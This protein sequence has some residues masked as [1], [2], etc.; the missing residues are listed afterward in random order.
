[1][2]MLVR[3]GVK[4]ILLAEIFYAYNSIAF[5]ILI[6]DKL[7]VTGVFNSAMTIVIRINKQHNQSGSC[8]SQYNQQR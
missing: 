3:V 8:F 1:M 7:A 2:N 4:Q 5:F 6:Y